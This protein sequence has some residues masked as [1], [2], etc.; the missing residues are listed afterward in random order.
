M[1]DGVHREEEVMF[2]AKAVTAVIV[3]GTLL[4]L[5]GCMSNRGNLTNA[6]DNLEYNANTLVR[7][8]HDDSARG[9]YRPPYERDARA[10][11]DDAHEFRRAVDDRAGDGDVRMAFERVSRSYH[12][13]RDEVA[14]SESLQAR[15]D[16]APVTDSY[17]QLEHD[18]GIYAE[19]DRQARADY[20]PVPENR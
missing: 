8:A 1:I 19:D 11:A 13:L 18:L 2:V 15:R 10:L 16:F 9:D 12:A 7:D 6:A 17:R 4:G 3:S 14:H 5:A 20:P